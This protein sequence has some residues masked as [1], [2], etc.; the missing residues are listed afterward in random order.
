MK[1]ADIQAKCYKKAAKKLREIAALELKPVHSLTEEEVAKIG[2][3]A[4]YAAT[5]KEYTKLTVG[6]LPTDVTNIILSYLPPYARLL[7]LSRR[8]DAVTLTNKIHEKKL[9]VTNM[10]HY[11]IKVRPLLDTFLN[12]NA[13]INTFMVH[14]CYYARHI[15]YARNLS[16]DIGAYTMCYGQRILTEVVNNYTNMYKKH[17][18]LT[19]R[20]AQFEAIVFKLFSD[21]LLS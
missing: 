8:Y 7:L 16:Q 20:H 21:I 3:R 6:D 14:L 1:Q 10:L 13:D 9:K 2:K 19:A 4:S 5:V 17:N 11:I 12:N 18:N 15:K